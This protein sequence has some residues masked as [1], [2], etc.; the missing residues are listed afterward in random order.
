MDA[1]HL[2]AMALGLG[3]GW[4]VV[5]SEMDVEGRR[6]R[7]WLDFE[8]GSL[9]ACPKCGEYGPVHDT[10]EKTWRHLN[11]WQH[12]TQLTARVPRTR[13]E[14]DGVLLT[15]VPWARAGS[16]FTLM[17]EAM[18]LLLCQ[19]MSVSAAARHLGESDTRLWRVVNHYVSQAHAARSWSGVKRVMIDETSAR[20]GHRYV[21]VVVDADTHDLLLMVEG[22]SADAVAELVAAMP[23]HGAHP[24]QIREVVMDM[25]PAYIAGVE[26]HF[27]GARIVFDLFHVM[28]LA[29][30]AL[31]RV[32]KEL[33]REGAD[34]RGSL[35]AIR[36]NEW[37]R[38]QE[39]LA[40]RRQVAAS[41]PAL[42][43]AMALRDSLQDVLKDSDLPSLKWW[44]GWAD[45][46]RLEP[47]RKLSRTLKEHFHG[48]LA[49]LQTRL[50]NAAIESI[51]GILQMAKRIA[52]G[53]RSFH[54]FRLAA[55]LKAGRLNLEVP[56]VLPT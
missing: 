55:Y 47:F 15:E 31:D 50:T 20:K 13:C 38:S 9:F 52:R 36:G 56:H 39:Q 51:N 22:R 19:Q 23:A 7:L 26:T 49:Y 18:I 4:K 17:M 29:G 30:E 45:R 3:S 16:G 28:K 33:R 40:Q 32:R 11:F 14:K 8:P 1:N 12:E 24:G 27:P 5:K 37:S 35:W 54:Y 53:Y 10:V 25:S 34:L 44:L 6:L 21:T 48:I 43:R 2:F 46:S 42:G 41:Y